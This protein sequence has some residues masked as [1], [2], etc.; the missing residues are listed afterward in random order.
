MNDPL[1]NAAITSETMAKAIDH[2]VLKPDATHADL[3]VLAEEA[4]THGFG[5][6]CVNSCHVKLFI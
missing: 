2:T 6:V 1:A 3:E 5:A 4:M